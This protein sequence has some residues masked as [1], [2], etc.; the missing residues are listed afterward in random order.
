VSSQGACSPH[1]LGDVN[2][3][4][5]TWEEEERVIVGGTNTGVVL[6]NIC[7]ILLF[8]G[9]IGMGLIPLLLNPIP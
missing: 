4:A 3:P 2:L 9:H 8:L 1:V 6:E 7:L 5:D